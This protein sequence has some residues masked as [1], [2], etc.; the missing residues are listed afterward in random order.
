MLKAITQQ[1]VLQSRNLSRRSKT[2][3][4]SPEYFKGLLLCKAK[5]GETLPCGHICDGPCHERD[6]YVLICSKRARNNLFCNHA[7]S[8]DALTISSPEDF[9]G[10]LLCQAK[11]GET[12]P[13]GHICDG[14]C[15]E[16]DRY[17]LIC[18]KRSRNNLFC[19]HATSQYAQSDHATIYFAITKPLAT[20]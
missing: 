19:N 7:T 5:C 1:F 12:L 10:L 11:C 9:K 15:H 8:R 17:V 16:R 3:I 20:L 18:S 4:S 13:C 14:P 2:N 6:R